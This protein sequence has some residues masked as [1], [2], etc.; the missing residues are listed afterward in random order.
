MVDEIVV[1]VAELE[2]KD[3]IALEISVVV[4]V[5][6]V[7]DELEWPHLR[8]PHLRPS[9]PTTVTQEMD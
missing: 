4:V 6:V 1:V 3:E 7:V 2:P 9:G 5:V 8:W